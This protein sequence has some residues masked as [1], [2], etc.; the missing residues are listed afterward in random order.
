[1][2]TKGLIALVATAM[3][4]LA[5]CGGGGD[6]S[7]KKLSYSAFGNAADKVCEK[8]NAEVD[9]ISNKLTGKVETDAPIYDELVP[10]LDDALDEF[11]ALKPPEALKPDFDKTVDLITQQTS[12]AKEAQTAAKNGDQDAYD[13]VI[14]KLR[15][16]SAQTKE[17]ESKLGAE[18][19]V[20]NE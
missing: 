3:L 7:N 18:Q 6:D 9:P 10:K 11:S 19:C 14:A 16:L 15:P 4:A 2:F 20:E 13:E 8:A 17:A 5:G 1:M 12:L